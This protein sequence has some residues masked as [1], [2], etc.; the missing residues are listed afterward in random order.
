MANIQVSPPGW[1]DAIKEMKQG[2]SVSN[3]HALAWHVKQQQ[4]RHTRIGYRPPSMEATQ[5]G[6]P[7]GRLLV[8]LMVEAKAN[9]AETGQSIENVCYEAAN[10]SDV[11]MNN[12]LN[13]G[14]G[15]H[16]HQEQAW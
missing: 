5:Y 9:L 3:L 4:V 15:I 16:I 13:A 12:I 2:S 1:E 6:T 10:G 8:D 14:H 7:T 11:A